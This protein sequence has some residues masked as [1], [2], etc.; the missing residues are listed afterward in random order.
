VYN[1]CGSS[2]TVE[3][4]DLLWDNSPGDSIK[5]YQKEFKI[6]SI[7]INLDTCECKFIG[8]E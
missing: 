4:T 1:W 2:T 5:F 6:I 3:A 7:D 8:R